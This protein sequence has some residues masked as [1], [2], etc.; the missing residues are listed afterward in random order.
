MALV[1]VQIDMK[2]VDLAATLLFNCRRKV[3]GARV[4]RFQETSVHLLN[5]GAPKQVNYDLW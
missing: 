4:G 5:T 1:C 2:L 3:A